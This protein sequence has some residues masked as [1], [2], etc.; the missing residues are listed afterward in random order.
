ML[1]YIAF[2]IF[3]VLSLV[4]FLI[5]PL[6]SIDLNLSSTFLTIATFLFAIF[7]GFFISRQG[8]R[9]ST[10]R[11]QITTFDGSMSAIF[12]FFGHLG[13]EPQ[14]EARGIIKYHYETIL[15]EKAW[16]YHFVHKSTTI[17]SMHDLLER[18]VGD[19]TLPS[20][21]NFALQRILFNLRILQVTRKSMIALHTERI[22]RFQWMLIIFLAAILLVAVSL[23]PSFHN[24]LGA[25]LKGAFGSAVIFVLILLSEFDKLKFFEGTIGER[26]AQ[27][28]LDIFS[29]KK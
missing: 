1:K 23:I 28:I 29:G 19:H 20:L 14:E 21:R 15:K 13:T 22:P 24:V 27:D 11:D 7:A 8:T 17:S 12:R 10:I 3:I 16:D 2:I 4:F 25:I 5:E 6:S 9:Y 26:S 18:V